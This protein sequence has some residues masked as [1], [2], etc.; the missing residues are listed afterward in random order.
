MSSYPIATEEVWRTTV[1]IARIETTNTAFNQIPAD[2]QAWLDIRFPA[3]D[4]NLNGRAVQ[5]ITEHLASFC[6]P[7]V[8]VTVNTVDPA[9]RINPQRQEI[10]L[11]RQAAQNQGYRADILRKHGTADSRFFRQRGIA[12]VIFGIGGDGQHGPYEYVDITTIAPYYRALTAFLADLNTSD[13]S[14]DC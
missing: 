5:E 3:E 2:A 1:N 10:R 6:V 7:G 4:T 11:L 12:T 14:H 13:P 9:C 8:T